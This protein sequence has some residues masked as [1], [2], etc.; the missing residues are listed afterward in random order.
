MLY[1][2]KAIKLSVGGRGGGG[3][4]FQCKKIIQNKSDNYNSMLKHAFVLRYKPTIQ[5]IYTNK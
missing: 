4:G 2:T 1:A 3:G 5:T